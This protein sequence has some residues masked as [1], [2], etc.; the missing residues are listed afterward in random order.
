MSVTYICPC[1]KLLA[2]PFP[3]A[4]N[5]RGEK[6]KRTGMV[7]KEVYNIDNIFDVVDYFVFFM[8]VFGPYFWQTL[9]GKNPCPSSIFIHELCEFTII[10]AIPDSK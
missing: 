4:G 7:F 8:V 9:I 10:L 5:S 3:S 2:G 1:L 6:R